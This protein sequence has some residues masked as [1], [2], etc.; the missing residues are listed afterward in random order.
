MKDLLVT[1][2]AAVVAT[3]ASAQSGAPSSAPKD[4]PGDVRNSAGGGFGRLRLVARRQEEK[5]APA[6]V[7][8]PTAKLS[9]AD[10][11]AAIKASDKAL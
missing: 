5:A 2:I 9:T 3:G 4:S 11:N 8:K 1:L 10:K 7:S 6:K